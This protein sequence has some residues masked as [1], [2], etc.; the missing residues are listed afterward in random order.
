MLRLVAP[1]T[2]LSIAL[3][4][5]SASRAPADVTV[6]VDSVVAMGF[7]GSPAR[8]LAP[9]GSDALACAAWRPTAIVYGETPYEVHL[10]VRPDRAQVV[11]AN[12]T[13]LP[14][15]GEVTLAGADAFSTAKTVTSRS[16]LGGC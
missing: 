8:I 9:A 15:I 2:A 1:V 12:V 4:G 3:V 16:A 6:V 11:T 5:C 7:D 13:R 10:R 14:G